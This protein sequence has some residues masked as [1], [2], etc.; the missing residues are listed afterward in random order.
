MHNSIY[1]DNA[2]FRKL[3]SGTLPRPKTLT[4][5]A[6]HIGKRAGD[7][8][9]RIIYDK[10]TGYLYYDPDGTG[11]AAQVRFAKLASWP[12]DDLCGFS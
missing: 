9:D 2:V 1:L 4:Q 3:G 7:A 5:D 10:G 6:F 11:S 8:E 12:E